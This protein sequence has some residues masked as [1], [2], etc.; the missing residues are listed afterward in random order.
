MKK[1]LSYF[2]LFEISLYVVTIVSIIISFFAFHNNQY[3][4]L[5]GSLIGATSLTF[6]AKGNP[7]GQVLTIVFSLFYGIVS[8]S[9]KYYGEMIT[10][11][12]MTLPIAV[13]ALF[14]WIKH[15]SQE[16][17]T[18]VKIKEL[19]AIN[20][21]LIIIV[22][23]VVTI[24]FYFILKALQTSNL[25]WST[26]SVFTSFLAVSLS[27]FRSRFYALAYALNDIVLIILWILASKIDQQYIPMIICF[28]AF[29]I[30][31]LYGFINWTKML[32]KQ[33]LTN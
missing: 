19:N 32:K 25:L 31:D 24:V 12:V 9:F 5:I 11:L 33:N 7:F 10:Y 15:P 6:L 28:I 4:Y 27:L 21:I 20:Y 2:T 13:C 16:S 14:S 18:Q 3:L 22:S 29:L 30:N 23:I 8:Y 26:L 17:K 1:I